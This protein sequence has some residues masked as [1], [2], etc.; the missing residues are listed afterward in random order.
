[1]S[2]PQPF[3]KKPVII[4]ACQWGT[5]DEGYLLE[6]WSE[7]RCVY[8]PHVS[9]GCGPNGEDWG[10]LEIPTLEGVMTA[11]PYDYIIRGV[12]GE[13]YPCKPDIFTQTYDPV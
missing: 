11:S 3:R 7:G 9:G 5:D 2:G 6:L 8:D 10:L 13:F 1:M 12:S 4:V